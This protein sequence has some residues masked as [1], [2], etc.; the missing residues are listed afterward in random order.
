[1]VE[2]QDLSDLQ[3]P[4]RLNLSDAPERPI[5]SSFSAESKAAPSHNKM[6]S[7]PPRISGLS[8]PLIKTENFGTMEN[9]TNVGISFKSDKIEYY[10]HKHEKL[11]Y[12]TFDVTYNRGL[13]YLGELQGGEKM[14]APRQ[15]LPF[16]KQRCP[17]YNLYNCLDSKGDK[18]WTFN[19]LEDIYRDK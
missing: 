8:P 2:N 10:N 17:T 6:T 14:V 13:L 12:L 16:Y 3:L 11:G 4:N 15:L 9:P 18:P 1:M 7:L 5:S 19:F